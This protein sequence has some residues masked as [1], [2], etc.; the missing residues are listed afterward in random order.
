MALYIGTS[1]WAYPEWRGTLYP[2]GLPQ[3]SFLEHYSGELTSCEINATFRRIHTAEAI[4][5]WARAVPDDFRFAAKAHRR[6]SYRKQITPN[7]AERA[8]VGEFLESLAPLGARLGCLMIQFPPFV[9]R[10]DAGLEQLLDLLPADLRFA[11]E[12]QN[13]G[14]DSGEVTAH[15]A[16]RGGTIC[17]REESGA[18]PKAL[19]P[20][21]VAYIRLKGEH[22]D[23]GERDT[24]RD[25]LG[26]EGR[27]RDVYVFARHKD[28]APDDP[29]TGLGLARWLVEASAR[30]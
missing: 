5:R 18:A 27:A 23:D 30:G 25:L 24:L 26:T 9:E 17:L 12:F 15:L 2:P 8:F 11:C 6:L 16:E 7:E 19:P 13:P 22:Y 1:G 28:V 21:P 29:H 3:R 14:W 20:G 10:D 4:A